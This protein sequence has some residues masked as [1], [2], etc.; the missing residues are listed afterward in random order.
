MKVHEIV[1]ASESHEST[2]EQRLD[3]GAVVA[4]AWVLNREQDHR[5]GMRK[6]AKEIV[7]HGPRMVSPRLFL[8]VGADR[9][10]HLGEEQPEEVRDLGGGGDGRPGV[11][12][13]VLLLDGDSRPDIDEPV[14]IR[15]IHLLQEHAGVGGERFHI[16]PL[17]FR[18]QGVEGQ[19]G[20]AG[21]GH[22]GDR[23]DCIVRNPQA[24]V[25]EVVLPCALD[26]QVAGLIN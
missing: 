11:A 17:A 4:G 12:D 14:Y 6:S 10:A 8:A 15:A 24:D 20:L 26:D 13:R 25:L 9:A 16:P 22:T 2:G 5:A 7:R 18:E 19:R 1:P 21:A 23:R 3:K